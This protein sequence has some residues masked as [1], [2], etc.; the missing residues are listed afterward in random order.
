[1]YIFMFI[2]IARIWLQA[3]DLA[4]THEEV[5]GSFCEPVYD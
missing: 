4:T 5:N 1:M 3:I 2:N